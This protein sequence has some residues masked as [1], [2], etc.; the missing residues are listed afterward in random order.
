MAKL[1]TVLVPVSFAKHSN[2]PP[3]RLAQ[4]AKRTAVRYDG[5]G[6]AFIGNPAGMYEHFFSTKDAKAAKRFRTAARTAGFKASIH[7][8]D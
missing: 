7:Q 2:V 6:M 5:G 1:Y 3:P 4:S 8:V